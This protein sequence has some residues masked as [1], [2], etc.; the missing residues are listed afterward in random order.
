MRARGKDGHHIGSY[1]MWLLVPG[2]RN[3]GGGQKYKRVNLATK[4][5]D[6]SN[7]RR[8]D[9]LATGKTDVLYDDDETAVATPSAPTPAPVI[10][11]VPA[12]LAAVET[13]RPVVL[14][15]EPAPLDQR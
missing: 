12:Q 8:A 6:K 3:P 13:P 10:P 2:E 14:P 1:F 15:P 4:D 9:A 11:V 7:D 5:F